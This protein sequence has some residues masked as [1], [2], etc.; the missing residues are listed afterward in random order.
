MPCLLICALFFFSFGERWLAVGRVCGDIRAQE[1]A[2]AA[3]AEEKQALLTK[4]EKLQDP[5][6]LTILAREKLCYIYPGETLCLPAKISNDVLL[7]AGSD[8]IIE[9]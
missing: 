4:K 2:L 6:Y 5:A 9:D 8:D 7:S 3:A 1:A